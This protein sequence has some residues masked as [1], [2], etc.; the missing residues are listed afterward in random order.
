M[1]AEKGVGSL[2]NFAKKT[3]DP[4]M[5]WGTVRGGW[6]DVGRTTAEKTPDPF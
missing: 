6:R 2:K 1:T 5:L 4:F 3:P